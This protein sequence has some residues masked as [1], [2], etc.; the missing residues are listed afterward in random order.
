MKPVPNTA[1]K[2]KSKVVIPVVESSTEKKI[3]K[4]VIKRAGSGFTPSIKD[5]IAGRLKADKEE[6]AKEKM[7]LYTGVQM[8]EPFT[9]EQF[10]VKWREYLERLN[11]RPSI[12][13][14]LGKIPTIEN[15]H[16][17][18]L[19]ISNYVQDEEINKIKPDMIAWL[20]KVLKNTNIE[21]ITTIEV[22]SDA[23]YRPYTETEKLNEMFKKNPNLKL[24][25]E[26][27]GL[28]LNE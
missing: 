28:S 11:D 10:E 1:P 22:S 17:L 19:N 13:V 14:A 9:K 4:R 5:A 12:K 6:D 15:G 24:L 18:K 27:L 26:K 23:N 20:R 21:L 2:K 3:V 16:L 25:A 7:K 8:N